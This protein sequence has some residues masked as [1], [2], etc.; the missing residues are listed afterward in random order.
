MLK[1]FRPS[2]I[3]SVKM[4]VFAVAYLEGTCTLRSLKNLDLAAY[5]EG[6]CTLRSLKNLDLAAYLEGRIFNSHID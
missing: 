4:S 3:R 6:A 1:H 5:L 2:W